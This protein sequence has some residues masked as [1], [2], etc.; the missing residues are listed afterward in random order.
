MANSAFTPLILDDKLPPEEKIKRA[1]K[2]L[3]ENKYNYNL[4]TQ[5]YSMPTR[6]PEVEP[7]LEN[8]KKDIETYKNVQSAVSQYHNELNAIK[9]E[10]A[11]KVKAY[12]DQITTAVEQKRSMELS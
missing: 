2:W 5:A 8:I 12:N 9:A 1:Q 6:P 3:Q 10:N 11:L 7:Y 4:I